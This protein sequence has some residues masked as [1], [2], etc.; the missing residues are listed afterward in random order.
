MAATPPT[1][2]TLAEGFRRHLLTSGR[3]RDT[4]T[5]YTAHLKPFYDWTGS[6]P[7]S[8]SRDVVS[9]YHADQLATVSRSTAHVRLA[10]IKAF[11]R[12]QLD[13]GPKD[14]P[15]QTKGLSVTK[16]I[17]QPR[18]PLGA[19]DAVKLLTACRS[20]EERLMFEV[21]LGC[22]LRI[23][24]IVGIKGSDVFKDRGVILI[25]GKGSKE[26]W[27]APSPRLLKELLLFAGGRSGG[28]FQFTREQARRIMMRVAHDAGVSGFHSHKLRITWAT[29]F[30]AETH[31]LHS[32]QVLMGH[33]DP[34]TTA[35]Y[36]AFEAQAQALEQMRRLN[37]ARG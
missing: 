19:G 35:R 25:R 13:L 22:G 31:D 27:V 4:A 3:S 37:E 11:F 24:E 20:D 17:R 23:S 21:G 12:W 15:P 7:L 36:A 5:T 29:Q 16:M 14:E 26:R 8:A 6:D 1:W 30:L 34:G 18:P 33:A 10:A 2:D 32:A 28:L 9:Y